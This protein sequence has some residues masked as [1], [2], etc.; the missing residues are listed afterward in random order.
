MQATD[1]FCLITTADTHTPCAVIDVGR[2]DL[3]ALPGFTDPTKAEYGRRAAELAERIGEETRVLIVT[4]ETLKD[5]IES[6]A[7]VDAVILGEVPGEPLV[8]VE[9]FVGYLEHGKDTPP[10]D[11]LAFLGGL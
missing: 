1:V 2:E 11:S 3:V 7:G 5:W 9:S 6:G 4:T 10:P 8:S